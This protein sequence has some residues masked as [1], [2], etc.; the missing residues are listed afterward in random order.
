[1]LASNL[2]SPGLCLLSG[3]DYRCEPQVPGYKGHFEYQKVRIEDRWINIIESIKK[4][5]S[6]SLFFSFLGSL[7]ELT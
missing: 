1:V 7:E 6:L 2:D 5:S 3:E 4:L